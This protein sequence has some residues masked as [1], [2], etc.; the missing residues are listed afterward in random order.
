MKKLL[1]LALAFIMVFSICACT[2]NNTNDK[3]NSNDKDK[4]E[5][6]PPPTKAPTVNPNF[7]I[8]AILL[9]DDSENHSKAHI[10]GL[11]AARV[12]LGIGD[13]QI[14]YKYSVPENEE[15]Y[16]AAVELAEQ[17]CSIIFATSS[18]HESYMIQAAKEY[19]FVLFCN[20]AGRTAAKQ[21]DLS[22]VFD[23]YTNIHESRYISGVV[24]GMKLKALMDA[25]TVSDP[26]IGYVGAFA[27]AEVIS[28]YTA[29]LLGV[30]S[31]VPEAHMDVQYTNSWCDAALEEA[32]AKA[33]MARGCV[34]IG[35]HV[36]STAVPAAVQAEY[37]NGSTVFVIGSNMDVLDIAPDAALT[38]SVS[39][40]SQYYTYA[41]DASLNGGSIEQD[42]CYGYADSTV[43]ISALGNSCAQGTQEAVD[44]AIAKIISGELKVFDCRNFTVNGEHLISYDNSFGFEGVELIDDG[45]FRE[46]ELIS[47]PL[48][49]IIIDGVTEVNSGNN[50][51]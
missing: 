38:S 17:G 51:L 3:N 19:P 2:D 42:W 45:H 20:F 7:K 13:G 22:N 33:L 16:E 46:S 15:C 10:E 25:G 27:N 34:I 30:R 35:Q 26:Y 48:F 14:I 41:I 23:Y 8:G 40:F 1:A 24:A 44:A 12:A 29:F 37:E 47:A 21:T 43:Q 4:T 9:G 31:I 18:G 36:N 32:A 5:I 50:S 28:G 39:V 11:E 6:T 49:D